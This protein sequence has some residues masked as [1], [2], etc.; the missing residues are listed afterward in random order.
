MSSHPP[1]ASVGRRLV[2]YLVDASL[3]WIVAIGLT[4]VVVVAPAPGLLRLLVGPIAVLAVW[5]ALAV[6][7]GRTGA[8]PGRAMLGLRVVGLD[9]ATP[10]GPGRAVLRQGLLGLLGPLNL[11]QVFVVAA[12]QRGLGWHDQAARSV[13]VPAAH[14]SGA[15]PS[16]AHAVAPGTAPSRLP[17]PPPGL[18]TPPRPAGP[19]ASSVGAPPSGGVTA[20]PPPPSVATTTGAVPVGPPPKVAPGPSIPTAATMLSAHAARAVPAPPLGGWVLTA[21]TVRR[22]V[23]GELLVGRDPDP[24]LA[25]GGAAWALDDIDLSVSKTHALFAATHDGGLTVVDRHS[26]NGIVISRSGHRAAVTS[27][28]PVAVS[29]G[30][31]VLLGDLEIRATQ[32]GPA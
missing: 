15:G 11:V 16:A 12:D 24:A 25:V 32:E 10:V 7:L 28:E 29:D 31:V 2:A 23:A 9:T 3:P 17:A 20:P 19:S 13:V 30:D 26:T 8:T 21:G 14:L 18:A 5:L 6:A 4:A 27:A 1:K 22:H